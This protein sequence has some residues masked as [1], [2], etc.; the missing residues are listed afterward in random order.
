MTKAMQIFNCDE[1]GVSI[2]HK[3][4]KVIAELGRRNVYSIMSAERGKTHTVLSCVSASG[5]S[6]PP[7]MVYPRKRA[8]PDNCREGAIAGTVFASSENGWMNGELYLEWFKWFLQN[9]SPARPVL[10]VQDGHGSHISIELIELACSNNVHLLC[11]PAHTTHVLQP[12]DVGVFKSFKSNFSKACSKYLA[13]YPGRVITTD[14][15][16]FLVAEAWPDS[17]TAVNIMSGFKK[18]GV[19]PLNPG[20][21]TDRQTAPSKALYQKKTEGA[22]VSPTSSSPP[23]FSPEKEALYKERFDEKY[24]IFDD[25]GYIAWIKINHPE[26]ALSPSVSSGNTGSIDG[27]TSSKSSVSDVLSDIP[28]LPQPYK[29]TRQPANLL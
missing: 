10:L 5:V 29:N 27:S 9:I 12:L 25:S 17:F 11:L 21:V 13:A 22:E 20:V 8:V 7:M 28:A 2:V 19:Y 3:P 16:A 14:K 4:T 23:L 18:C 26:F 15:L 24:D 1:T 6:L